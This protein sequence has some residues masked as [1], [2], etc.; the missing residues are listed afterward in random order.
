MPNG[1]DDGMLETLCL[2]SVVGN[3][4]Y[5]CLTDY[6]SC[7]QGHG[8]VP[9]NMHKGTHDKDKLINRISANRLAIYILFP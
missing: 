2:Q 1:A 5:P 8:A 7:L 9:N 3:P 4:E 6:F